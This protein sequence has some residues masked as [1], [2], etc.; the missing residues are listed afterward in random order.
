MS[1]SEYGSRE[2][3]GEREFGQIKSD[4]TNREEGITS[5]IVHAAI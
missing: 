4:G 5:K 2:S 1:G 3:M